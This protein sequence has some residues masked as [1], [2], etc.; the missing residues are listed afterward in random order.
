[1]L[2]ARRGAILRALVRTCTLDIHVRPFVRLPVRCQWASP[3]SGY[4]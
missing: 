1:M 2:Y 3:R 4:C